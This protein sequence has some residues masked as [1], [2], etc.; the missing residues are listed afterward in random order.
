MVSPSFEILLQLE[1]T[2]AFSFW[3]LVLLS[4]LSR[5]YCFTFLN[6]DCFLFSPSQ[7]LCSFQGTQIRESSWS[8]KEPWLQGVKRP[9]KQYKQLKVIVQITVLLVCVLL[10][11]KLWHCL[12]YRYRALSIQPKLLNIWKTW[13]TV[14][15]FPWKVSR[16][17]S[18]CLISEMWTIEPKILEIEWRE[19]FWYN[20][21]ENLGIPCKVALFLEIFGSFVP[22]VTGSFWKFKS[23]PGY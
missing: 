15:K 2:L 4:Y 16:N 20:V 7:A 21:F 23:Y 9:F 5:Q 14:Q 1:R 18:N 12:H 8:Q 13:Q 3:T 19:D 11:N 10:M 17:S 6:L 22:F